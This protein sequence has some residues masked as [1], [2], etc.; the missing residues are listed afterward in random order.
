MW[1]EYK[2]GVFDPDIYLEPVWAIYGSQ[3]FDYPIAV[4][5]AF[6]GELISW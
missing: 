4:F 3:S 6:D 1:Y 5:D 2:G